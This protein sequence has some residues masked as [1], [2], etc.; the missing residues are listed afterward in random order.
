[1]LK[2]II[3][4]PV[5]VT[6]ALLVVVVLGFV[7]IRLLPISLIPDIDI[8]YITVQTDAPDLSAREVDRTVML[9]L[10]QQLIQIQS[11]EDIS[12]EAVDGG[13]VIRLTFSQGTD[14]DY[15]FI[16]VNEKI[17]RC[18]STLGDIPRPRAIKSGAADIPAFYVNMTLKGEGDFAALSR[19]SSDVVSKRLEQLP[20]VAMV[21]ISGLTKDEIL[22]IPDKD[23]LIASGLDEAAFE[24]L[25]KAANI[26]LGSL[27]IRDGEY[28]YSVKFRSFAGGKED[29]EDIWLNNNGRLVQVKDIAE[30]IEHPA[31]RTGLVRSDGKDAVTM[32]VIKQSDARMSD[33]RKGIDRLMDQFSTDYPDVEFTVTRD[34]TQLLEYSVNNLLANI[35]IGILLACVVIFL[36]M[37]DFRSPMLVALTMPVSLIFAMLVFYVTGLSIN[38]IS[39]SGLILGVGMITDNTVVLID[40]I[41]A[42]W[43]RGDTLREAVLQGTREVSGPMLSSVLTTVAVFIPLIFISGTAGAMFYDQAMAV[44]IV[45]FTSYF[46]TITVIP[47][48]YWWWYKGQEAFRPNPLLAKFSFEGLS[49]RYEDG[50]AWVFRHRWTAWGVFAGS[51]LTALLCFAFMPKQRLPEITYEDTL[52]KVEWNGQLSLENNCDRVGEIESLVKDRVQQITS[53]IGVQ[54]FVLSHSGENGVSEALIYMKCKGARSLERTKEAVSGYLAERYPECVFAFSPS[55][56]IFEE[57]FADKEEALVARLRPVSSSGLRADKV[58]TAVNDIS[59]AL[60]W[61]PVPEVGTKRDILY[62]ADPERMALYDVSYSELVSSLKNSLNENRLFVIVNGDHS[63]PVLMGTDARKVS[64]IVENTFVRKDGRDIP[65]GALMR[66]TWEDDLRSIVSGPEGNIYPVGLDVPGHSVP[67]A[68]SSIRKAIRER[69]DFEVGFSGSWFSS[70]KMLRE[71]LL[72]LLVALSLLYLILASQFESLLQPLIVLSEVVI[73]IAFALLVLWAVGS[74]IN[75]MSLIGLVV[76][77]GIVINDSILKIDTINKLLKTGMSLKH[78][79]MEAGR[80]RLKAIVMT[81]LTTI[82]AV[83]PFLARGSMGSDLQFPMSVTIIAGMVIGTLVSVFFIPVVYYGFY[84]RKVK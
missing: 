41:T 8:P 61:V 35:V 52:L 6:M 70:R 2:W 4:R 71:M 7:S 28:R 77:T 29:I 58:R 21:D 33:L 27:S 75:L 17:D 3:D 40:N 25:V 9:P 1:M 79:I 80:R 19:F 37:K 59:R 13:G 49:D 78:A 34:Q 60:P 15:L 48:F 65:V 43:Q 12:C 10:R 30:V 46:I 31:K 84:H 44:T 66:Q 53:M 76:I 67:K 16:E 20:E 5:T 72:V 47:V 73:D 39:L 11:L 69:G 81:S 23:A 36:F 14:M 26:R 83:S 54:Q 50:L 64:D 56:N 45:L 32:A 82:L 24:N 42:R 74:S 22:L 38:I 63:V 68:M 51:L 55:G 18:M 57:V 62:L